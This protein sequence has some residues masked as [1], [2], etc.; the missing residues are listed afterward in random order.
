MTGHGHSHGDSI[1][2]TLDR[3]SA[4]GIRSLQVSAAGLL[5][6]AAIQ[7]V[8]VALG[9]SAGLL[10]EAMHNLGDV[11]T[12]A[13]LWIAFVATRRAADDRYTFGY[14]RFED[15]AGLGIVVAIFASAALA[16]VESVLHLVSGSRPTHLAA[17][18]AAAV[19]GIAGNEG[20]AQYKIA[21][22]RRIGSEALIAEGTHSRAD[23]AASG[24]A[25]AG[26]AGAAL[27][28]AWADA[29]AG[30]LISLFIAWLGLQSARPILAKLAD[31]VDPAVIERIAR[32]AAGV[33]EV[34]SV[35]DIRA[36]W[37]GRGLYISL[38]LDFPPEMT[39]AEAHAHGERLRH[40]VLH[41]LPQVAQLD[42]H[43]DPHG[44][45][46]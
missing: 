2:E 9:G 11:L 29:T 31:R 30:L 40:E 28:Q 36:R 27:G 23:G 22:G 25:L 12:S 17:G 45:V 39:V 6:T 19:V 24:A 44:V 32:A 41:E 34:I 18:M 42:F 1:G 5:V 38:H 26:L 7:L 43:I 21:V 35:H 15:L 46:H 33:E 8:V 14:Q 3:G 37:A 20:V 16:G 4:E 10:A 13:A